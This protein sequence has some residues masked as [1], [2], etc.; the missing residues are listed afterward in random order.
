MKNQK[1]S[2]IRK[3]TVIILEMALLLCGCSK[4]ED[5]TDPIIEQKPVE[6]TIVIPTELSNIYADYDNPSFE[7]DGKLYTLGQFTLQDLLDVGAIICDDG[8]LYDDSIELF[9]SNPDEMLR[10]DW[11]LSFDIFLEEGIWFE[12]TVHNNTD[13]PKRAA[14][15][16]V[17]SLTISFKNDRTKTSC[18]FSASWN[19]IIEN[20]GTPT[21]I[22]GDE[23]N[24]DIEY[25]RYED[26]NTTYSS[27]IFSFWEGELDGILIDVQLQ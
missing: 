10:S 5:T 12:V 20:S 16:K 7:W 14:D 22:S 13:E 19:D 3:T 23:M 4:V 18:P 8:I 26:E 24:G 21:S 2:Y 6:H 25:T 17:E 15:C 27:Y 1:K 9:I 11:V